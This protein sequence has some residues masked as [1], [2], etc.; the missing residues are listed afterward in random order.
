MIFQLSLSVALLEIVIAAALPLTINDAPHRIIHQFDNGFWAENLAVRSNGKLLI[1]MVAPQPQ[2]YQLDPLS[3]NPVPELIATFPNHLAALGIDEIEHD[4]FAIVANNFTLASFGSTLGSNTV[5]R[6]DMRSY[7]EHRKANVS[8]LADVPNAVFLNGFT[9][10]K[11][12]P[13]AVVL[14]SDSFKG[15][16]IEIDA[17]TG[18]SKVWLDTPSLHFPVGGLGIGVNGVRYNQKDGFVYFSI[19]TRGVVGRVLYKPHGTCGNETKAIQTVAT[20]NTTIDDIIVA[21]NGD[22]FAA[23]GPA[24]ELYLIKKGSGRLSRILGE[25]DSLELSGATAAR[26]GRT[27]ADGHIL[28]VTTDGGVAAPING[29]LTEP[30]KVVAVD[31]RGL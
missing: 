29:T 30:G 19:T 8:V 6:I 24:N 16:I 28:Y 11:N 15:Q 14:A 25:T 26:F 13:G 5:Y 31:T 10:V 27:K 20:A 1:T 12:G 9:T 21:H 17:K 4:I 23:G 18:T 2:V 7:D 22:V 3:P